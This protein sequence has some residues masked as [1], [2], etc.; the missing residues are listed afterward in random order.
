MLDK[1]LII[2]LEIGFG[3]KFNIVGTISLSE[4]ALI[5][6]SFFFVKQYYFRRFPIVLTITWLYLALLLAQILSEILLHNIMANALK[7][8]AITIV[9]YLHFFFLM[10]RFIKDRKLMIFALIG[11]LVNQLIF[12]GEFEGDLAEVVEGEGVR[13]LKFYLAPFITQV[14]LILSI[15]FRKQTIS[16]ICMFFG[17]AF[18]VLGARSSGLMIFITGAFV[19]FLVFNQRKLNRKNILRTLS[20]LLVFG[21]GAYAIYVTNVLNGKIKAGNSDQL[22][23]AEHPY[24]PINLLL[25]G[26]SEVFVGWIAFMDSPWIGHGAWADDVGQKYHTIQESISKTEYFNEDIN[27]IPAHSVLIGKGMENGVVAFVLM[28]AILYLFLSKGFYGIGKRDPYIFIIVFSVMYILWHGLF[29]PISS[30]RLTLPPYFAFLLVSALLKENFHR[31]NAIAQFMIK[32][33]NERD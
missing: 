20:V 11:M 4:M 10:T 19:Y 5:L 7:G 23:R 3:I 9:S 13:Y 25:I 32:K 26:R 14:I 12:G 27:V 2:L 17:I 28:G 31:K 15:Y 33:K 24:N 22:Y 1:I 30:F 21:Y 29:S 16:I 18:I 8:Y 6:T